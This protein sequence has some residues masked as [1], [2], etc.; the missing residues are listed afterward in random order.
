[1]TFFNILVYS[2]RYPAS[3]MSL[4]YPSIG[5]YPFTAQNRISSAC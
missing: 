4:I 1:M 5:S 2:S 3:S